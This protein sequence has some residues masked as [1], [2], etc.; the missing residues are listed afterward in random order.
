VFTTPIRREKLLLAKALVWPEH[1]DRHTLLTAAVALAREQPPRIVPGDGA[2]VLPAVMAEAPAGA[3][4]CVYDSY[5]LNQVPRVIRSRVLAHLAEHAAVRDL[6]RV[7]QEGYSLTEPPHV[8]LTTYRKRGVR[9][10]L[11]ARTESHGRWLER[12]EMG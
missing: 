3:V 5:T 9:N 7:A 2:E 6:Y 10:D 4:L 11:L 12:I 1:T 8:E